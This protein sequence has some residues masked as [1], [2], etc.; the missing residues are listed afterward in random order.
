MVNWDRF[1]LKGSKEYRLLVTAT[2]FLVGLIWIARDEYANPKWTATPRAGAMSS[3]E[4]DDWNKQFGPADKSKWAIPLEKNAEIIKSLNP[5]PVA[6][7][8]E[9]PKRATW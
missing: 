1:P 8:P 6:T 2:G 9:V 5:A 4:I 3:A 7:V